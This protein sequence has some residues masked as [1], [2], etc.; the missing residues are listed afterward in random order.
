M[1]LIISMLM[2]ERGRKTV[3]HLFVQL[4]LKMTSVALSELGGNCN[5]YVEKNKK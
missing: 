2:S 3:N 1:F 5:I 4:I